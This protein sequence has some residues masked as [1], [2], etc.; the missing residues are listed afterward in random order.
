MGLRIVILDDDR[1]AALKL[2][3]R[4]TVDLGHIVDV[5][6]DP[7]EFRE[8]VLSERYDLQIVD[9]RLPN[10]EASVGLRDGPSIVAVTAAQGAHVPTVFL[11]QWATDCA[12]RVNEF[13]PRL[14]CIVIEKPTVTDIDT[15]TAQI[16]LAID[17]VGAHVPD[18]LPETLGVPLSDTDSD[19][20]KLSVRCLHALDEEDRDD[21][22]AEVSQELYDRLDPV[23]SAC[24]ADWLKL[25]RF[26]DAIM[27]IDRGS[28]SEL[29]TEEEVLEGEEDYGSGSLIVGRP[30]VVEEVGSI[31]TPA[32]SGKDWRR[33]PFVEVTIN[34]RAQQF[35]VDT[36][37]FYSFIG[38]DFLRDSGVPEPRTRWMARS[39][40][41]SSGRGDTQFHKPV[42]I[43]MLVDGPVGHVELAVH[44]YI[45]KHWRSM[46]NVLN[47]PCVHQRCPGSVDGQCGRRLGLM[48]RGLLY[49][50]E[51]GVWHFKPDSGEF[52]PVP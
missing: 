9:H 37:S 28:D 41:D 17:R 23:W 21:L 11:T 39:V 46:G 10:A 2:A 33:Y 38:R 27:V 34:K 20:F 43:P 4:A 48:G 13:D 47:H 7:A 40:R 22:E 29:P 5:T 1:D 19:F 18:H 31:C 25:Q 35:H 49:H 42:T 8:L 6:A 52:V 50:L 32:A 14:V 36:G 24:D 16:H 30:M 51:H 26:G 45:V 12:D 44:I 3:Q 15:W